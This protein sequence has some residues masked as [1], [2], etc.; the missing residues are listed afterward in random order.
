MNVQDVAW[1]DDM[2]LDITSVDLQHKLLAEK[3]E[4][5]KACV[6]S[7]NGSDMIIIVFDQLVS[8]LADHFEHEET[9]MRNIAYPEAHRHKMVHGSVLSKVLSY[10]SAFEELDEIRI[11]S[12]VKFL[13]RTLTSHLSAEDRKIYDYMHRP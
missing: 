5:L 1:T 13:E 4:V 10:R 2:S 8:L 6:S 11:S 9:I 12:G 7:Q 3:L